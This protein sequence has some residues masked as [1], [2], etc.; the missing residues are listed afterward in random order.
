MTSHQVLL[1]CI[2]DSVLINYVVIIS[3]IDVLCNIHTFGLENVA[4]LY[5]SNIKCMQPY[6]QF[7]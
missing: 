6:G 1:I 7:A 3:I 2:S 4:I 5:M